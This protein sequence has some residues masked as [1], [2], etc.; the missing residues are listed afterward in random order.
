MGKLLIAAFFM[1]L[2]CAAPAHCA[3]P[4]FEAYPTTVQFSGSLATVDVLSHPK[5]KKFKTVLSAGAKHG[6]NFAG[7]YIIVTWGCGTACQEIAIVDAENGKVYFPGILKLNAYQMVHDETEPFQ[8]KKESNLLVVSGS[9]NDQEAL[10]VHYYLWDNNK[11]R[12]VHET[13]R[14]FEPR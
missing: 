5:A 13:N 1:L 4:S 11:L 3:E 2:A 14:Q 12:K 10:G 8:F 7:H 6:P 9:P